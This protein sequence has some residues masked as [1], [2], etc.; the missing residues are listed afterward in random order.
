MKI[1][2]G[3]FCNNGIKHKMRIYID[4]QCLIPYGNST[5][6][7]ETYIDN[8]SK[9]TLVGHHKIMIDGI[10]YFIETKIINHV[11]V[12]YGIQEFNFFQKLFSYF[13]IPNHFVV[14]NK[15]EV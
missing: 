13:I 4:P 5:I 3:F 6:V 15:E 7:A 1:F 10:F 2:N 14:S 9:K 8:I 11:L 12:I